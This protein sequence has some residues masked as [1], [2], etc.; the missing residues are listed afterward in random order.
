MVNINIFQNIYFVI[1]FLKNP[2]SSYEFEHLYRPFYIRGI[3]FFAGLLAG[4]IIEELK[5]IEFK[6]SKVSLFK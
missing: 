4:V 5:K 6:M 3:P 2:S 1:R